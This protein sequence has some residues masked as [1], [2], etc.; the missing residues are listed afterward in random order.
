MDM[1]FWLPI[2]NL[3]HWKC[4]NFLSTYIFFSN[5]F[6]VGFLGGLSLHLNHLIASRAAN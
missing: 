6:S 3:K 2:L 5:M 1:K 4:Q